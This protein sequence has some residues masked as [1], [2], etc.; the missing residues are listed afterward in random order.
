MKPRL[1]RLILAGWLA[2]VACAHGEADPREHWA[3]RP[4]VRPAVPEA[5]GK[6]WAKNPIDSFIFRDLEAQGLTPQKEAAPEVLLRRLYLDLVGVPPPLEEVE[7]VLREAPPGWY[8]ATVDRLLA[9]PRHGE[10]WARH[11]MD[12]WRY[13]DW[14]GLGEQLRNSQKHMWHWRDWIVESLNADTPYDEMVRLMLAADEI[15]P[16]DPQKLRATG[17]LAR[18]FFLFNRNPWMEE[19]VEHVSKGF[20][21]LTMNCA[22]CHDHKYDPVTQADYYRMRAFFEPLQVRMDVV[23]GQADLEKDGIPRVYDGQPETPT[24][25]YVRGNEN[26]PDKSAVMAPGVPAVLDFGRLAVQPVTLP[27]EAA[28]PERQPWVLEAHTAAARKKVEVAAAAAAKD[29]KSKTAPYAAALAAAE[30][31]DVEARA[32]AMQAEWAGLPDARSKA[33]AA[34]R[35]GRLVGLAQALL[36]VAE[37]EAKLAGAAADKREGIEKELNE[38]REKA[39]KSATVLAEPVKPEETFVQLTGA[40]WT[41]TRFRDSGKDDPLVPFP[42]MSTGRRTALAR[43]VTDAKNPLTARV[44]VNHL[45]GRHTGTP[46]VAMVFEFGRKGAAPANPQLLDWLAAELVEK[47]WSLKHL[48]RLIV[49]SA[50]YRLSSSTAGAGENEAID[51]ENTHLWR[52]S[53]LRLEAQVVRDSLLA[54]SGDLDPA[55]G[56]PPVP[57]AAQEESKRRSLYFFRSSNEGSQFLTTFD[58]APVKECYRRDQSIVPQQA[59]ALTNSRL[60]N[61][62]AERISKKLARA[63]DDDAAFVRRAFAALMAMRPC[64]AEVAACTRA[65]EAWRAADTSAEKDAA[66]RTQLIRTLINHDDFVTLR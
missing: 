63:G 46:L 3:F 9:D 64:E 21:G 43:W 33:E 48:H 40:K 14:W 10:R 55:M 6:G 60:V 61:D 18:N 35:G 45:W 15:A 53:S 65:L 22:K 50:A 19:T 12:I 32:G 58:D 20:L 25:L 29:G 5:A 7:S 26:Q 4:V 44:A 8:E 57:P 59:L 62:A 2:G 56:G 30:L 66:A 28:K 47:G 52:R 49:T 36:K 37:T 13:S 54:V 16:G 24:Y 42:A 11:W 51:L 41:P 39:G 1:P 17:F 23:P 34:V 38:A 31:A 27:V